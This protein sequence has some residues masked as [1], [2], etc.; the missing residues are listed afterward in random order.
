MAEERKL[1]QENVA[2]VKKRKGTKK[3]PEAVTD[4]EFINED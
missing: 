4:S 1:T 3:N 2:P